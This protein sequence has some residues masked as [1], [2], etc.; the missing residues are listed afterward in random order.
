MGTKGF[1]IL[2]GTVAVSTLLTGCVTGPPREGHGETVHEKLLPTDSSAVREEADRQFDEIYPGFGDHLWVWA[3]DRWLDLADIAKLDIEFGRGFGV[4]VH[5]TELLQAGI[6]WWDGS[7]L[8]MRGR[9]FGIWQESRNHGGLGPFYW[10]D[11]K[12]TPTWGT[13]NLF[14]HEYAYTGWDL[15]EESGNKA[16][17]HDWT[18]V[19]AN[20]QVL[21]IGAQV[22]GSPIE[23][24]DFV[25]G[26]VTL[27]AADIM[28]DDTKA[29]LEARLREEKGLGQ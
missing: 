29:I 20:A 17:D 22:A 2:L 14:D 6:G 19:G 18:E 24:A 8:G 11:V 7:S 26:F 25:F 15:F 3:R 5:A 16:I 9:A 1:A 13:A 10:V 23:I 21:A 28:N 27:G 4:N 12:R